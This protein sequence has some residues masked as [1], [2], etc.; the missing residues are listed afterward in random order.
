MAVPPISPARTP[1]VVRAVPVPLLLDLVVGLLVVVALPLAILAIPNTISVVAALLPADV[2]QVAMM[3]AHGLALPAMLL[4]VPL[5]AI[6]VRRLGAAPMAVAGLAL[7]AV[8]DAAGGFADSATTVA[9][10]RVLHGIGAG[11]VVPA[12]LVAVAERPRRAVLMPLWASVF[13]VSLLIG[14]ALA[15]WPIDDATSWR[16]TLQPYPLLTG[17]ALALAAVHLVL[18]LFAEDT[19]APERPPA[20][21][22]GRLLLAALPAVGVTVL[23]V[24]TTFDWPPALVIV[25]AI[26]S[27]LAMLAVGTVGALDG[28]AGRTLAFANVAVGLVVLPTTAQATYVELGGLG[29]PGLSGL[30]LPFVIAVLA[31]VAAAYLAGKASLPRAATLTG[32]GLAT[33]VA[34]LCAMRLLVPASSGLVMV[35]PFAL[36]AVGSAVALVSALRAVSVG[37]A[38]LGLSF[39]FPAVLAG[40]LLGTGVQVIRLREVSRSGGVTRQ[41]LLDAFVGALHVWALAGGFAVVA[42]VVLAT[43]LAR[44]MT[45]RSPAKGTDVDDVGSDEVSR[46]ADENATR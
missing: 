19:R 46:G 43:V 15:L 45:G 31:A 3:R 33:L 34:G 6:A 42:I 10:L 28:M 27:V 8:A 2:S 22:R 4:T 13:A 16:V 21:E 9:V 37:S 25:L 1:S 44:R 35:V 5:G 23:G 41:A 17:I 32:G 12:T 30:W 39:C 11:L 20:S 36:L 38:L 40:Y 7:L 18:G 24:G 26:A 29:G 14:Q